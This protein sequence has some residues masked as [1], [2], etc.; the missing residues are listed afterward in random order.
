MVRKLE[1][2]GDNW[3]VEEFRGN[4]LW[5]LNCY[6]CCCCC[7]ISWES[8]GGFVQGASKRMRNSRQRKSSGRSRPNLPLPPLIPHTTLCT[9][10]AFL[11]GL[12][13][14]SLNN[15]CKLF[16]HIPC[17]HSWWCLGQHLFLTTDTFFPVKIYWCTWHFWLLSTP[18]FTLP[19]GIRSAVSLGGEIGPEMAHPSFPLPP[20]REACRF[21]VLSMP[22]LACST[23]PEELCAQIYLPNSNRP[24]A[25]LSKNY[26]W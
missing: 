5:A 3:L 22:W 19:Q 17:D 23:A 7:V 20:H 6:C 9:R 21:P 1:N 16:L 8:A 26:F 10:K 15:Y 4:G 18:L 12:E 14:V 24:K 25:I 2:F 11:W 13:F